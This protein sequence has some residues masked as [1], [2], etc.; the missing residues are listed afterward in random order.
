MKINLKSI[1][2]LHQVF[3]FGGA[4]KITM[5]MA[6]Y[7]VDQHFDVTVLTTHHDESA[8]PSGFH[9]LFNVV[10]LPHGS[11]KTSPR[12]AGAVRDYI[13]FHEVTS[14]VSYREVL[15]A[16]WLRKKTGVKFIF[17]LMSKPGYE[18]DGQPL[19]AWFY[20]LKYHR[21]FRSSDIYGVICESY[22]EEIG[23][24]ISLPATTE[25]IRIIPC[26]IPLPENVCMTKQKV[27]VYIGRLSRRDKRLDRLLRIWHLASP[28]M[29]EWQLKIVGR[30][31]EE[32]A[33]RQQA[34]N[35]CLQNI[36]FEGYSDHV[37]LYFN[38][39]SI[40]CL[41]SSFEGWPLCVAEAQANGVI[42][43]IFDSFGGARDLIRNAKE[44]IL[45]KPF[46]ENLFA[47]ELVGLSHDSI[48]FAE[49]QN[50]VID[51]AKNYSIEQAG[52]KWINSIIS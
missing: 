49:M 26:F 42:P 48:R 22:K 38:E 14:I 35:L 11:I 27:V 19:L 47:Q 8:Y 41:T 17:A 32:E 52:K 40:L 50:A 29:P 43:I 5:D 25:K 9:R 20:R 45:V 31:P 12:I 28:Q 7:L 39:A 24:I 3:P 21:V 51:K 16:P 10:E 1:A 2:F 13:K 6:N 36:S 4:E 44:G 34:V 37:Q 23:K 18:F 46:D 15:Y 33:L 30:G